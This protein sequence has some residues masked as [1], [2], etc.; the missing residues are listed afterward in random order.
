[1]C[2]SK[3]P[4]YPSLSQF[5]P[6]SPVGIRTF[7]CKSRTLVLRLT[8]RIAFR[9]WLP[10]RVSVCT[11][12]SLETLR[13][14]LTQF[15]VFW[16]VFRRYLVRNLDGTSTTQPVNSVI[17]WVH[18]IKFSMWPQIRPRP[19]HVIF[20]STSTNLPIILGYIVPNNGSVIKQATIK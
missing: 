19:L 20:S 8:E 3:L 14:N 18:P 7:T 5:I 10:V 11:T 9:N 13:S 16:L 15:Q 17:S 2:H 4:V 12:G 6:V 1:V